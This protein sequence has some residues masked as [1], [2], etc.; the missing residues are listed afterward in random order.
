M[1]GRYLH[2]ISACILGVFVILHLGNHAVLFLG[3]DQAALWHQRIQD[4]LRLFYRQ[5]Q[6]EPVL[7]ASVIVQITTGLRLLIRRGWPKRRAMHVQSVTG[8]VLAFFI[9][10]HVSAVLMARIGWPSGLDGTQSLDTT[11]YF[12]ASVLHPDALPAYFAPYY[13]SGTAAIGLHLASFAM[14]RR[15]RILA[16][17]LTGIS[18]L[19]ATLITAGLWRIAQGPLPQPYLDYIARTFG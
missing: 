11:I 3:P 1:R 15:R 18:I 6:I 8:A 9:I 4:L 13:L 10:Q 17:S 5:P 19:F 12:A 14:I 2:R 7:I 16:L